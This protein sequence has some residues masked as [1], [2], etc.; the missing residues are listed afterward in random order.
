ML[1]T[2]QNDLYYG[3]FRSACTTGRLLA[4]C[5]PPVYPSTVC[6]VY[7]SWAIRSGVVVLV[8]S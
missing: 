7:P 8:A 6:S 3:S 1:F 5:F 4:F 2:V